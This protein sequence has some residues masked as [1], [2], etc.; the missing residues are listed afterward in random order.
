MDKSLIC[1]LYAKFFKCNLDKSINT[2]KLKRL[3]YVNTKNFNK[4]FKENILKIKEILNKNKILFFSMGGDYFRAET[5]LEETFL[6]DENND[7]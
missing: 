6:G 5:E 4:F 1:N 2:Y 7:N 3:K